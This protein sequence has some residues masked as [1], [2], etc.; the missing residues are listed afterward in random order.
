MSDLSGSQ[1]PTNSHTSPSDQSQA[2][3]TQS[4]K[5]G[6]KDALLKQKSLLDGI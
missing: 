2:V 6:Q 5:S 4:Q 3:D 1:P